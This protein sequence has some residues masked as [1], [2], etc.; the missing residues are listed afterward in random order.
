M[1]GAGGGGVHGH[2]EFISEDAYL[3]TI[4]RY[5][6]LLKTFSSVEEWDWRRIYYVRMY[7]HT[8]LSQFFTCY[9]TVLI[10]YTHFLACSCCKFWINVLF[11]IRKCDVK[12]INAA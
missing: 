3:Q 1:G 7:I 12:L 10:M 6:L 11:K 9:K 4:E 8:N 2:N 5:V